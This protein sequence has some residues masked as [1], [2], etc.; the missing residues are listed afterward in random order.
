MP[1]ARKIPCA[2]FAPGRSTCLLALKVVNRPGALAAMSKLMAEHGINIL[3]GLICAEPEEGEAT[4]VSFMD[5]TNTGLSP[6]DLVEELKNLDVVLDAEAVGLRVGDLMIDTFSF[7][8]TF[9]TRRVVLF[10]LDGVAAMLGWV[11]EALETGGHVILYEMGHQAGKTVVKSFKE[12]FGLSG[13]T[14]FEA[15]LAFGTAMG[16]FRYEVASLDPSSPRAIV[17]LFDSFECSPFAG[18][19]RPRSHLLR[20]FLAGAFEEAFGVE[21]IAREGLCKAKGDEFCEFT[22]EA[23]M[24]EKHD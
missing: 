2:V 18:S 10:D 13:Q 21:A 23:R 9:L 1:F 6:E 8:T 24:G 22:I 20:G 17:R 14:A 19:N 4:W 15:L 7:P 5:L 3:S 16:W 11:D 12:K